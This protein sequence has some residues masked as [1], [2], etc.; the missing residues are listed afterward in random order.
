M[1]SAD[2]H[3]SRAFQMLGQAGLDTHLENPWAGNLS[4]CRGITTK[5]M[6]CG[7]PIDQMKAQAEP[8]LQRLATS[9][10]T[11]DF[12]RLIEGLIG[13]IHCHRHGYR[14]KEQFEGWWV[15][16]EAK[17]KA[18]ARHSDS[19]RSGGPQEQCR[20]RKLALRGE[21]RA[22]E[23]DDI[24]QDGRDYSRPTSRLPHTAK[25]PSRSL[26]KAEATSWSRNGR[27]DENDHAETSAY[28]AHLPADPSPASNSVASANF[29]SEATPSGNSPATPLTIPD[30]DSPTSPIPSWESRVTVPE[31]PTKPGRTNMQP[32][33]GTTKKPF[34]L[35]EPGQD[36]ENADYTTVQTTASKTSG[37]GKCTRSRRPQTPDYIDPNLGGVKYT[38][39]S[40]TKW[41][42]L[43]KIEKQFTDTEN[44]FGS[45]YILQHD[46]DPSCCKVGFTE[47]PVEKRAKQQKCYTSPPVWW[48]GQFRGAN[49]V[50]ALVKEDLAR[51][52]LR[53]VKCKSCEKGH[54]EWFR[55]DRDTLEKKIRAWRSLVQ[56]PLYDDE[57]QVCE[58]E[59]YAL[60]HAVDVSP[61]RLAKVVWSQSKE[62]RRD[63]PAAGRVDG[64]KSLP[65]RVQ[66]GAKFALQKLKPLP[67]EKPPN[68]KLDHGGNTALVR[69]HTMKEMIQRRM[70][71][72]SS[73][74]G[75]SDDAG[76]RREKVLDGWRRM[77]E[78]FR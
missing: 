4:K 54:T 72:F 60:G 43:K 57:G 65:L 28:D 6:P 69:R 63:H 26:R 51:Q 48:T 9:S 25:T 52:Q 66:G 13:S 34:K 16:N 27:E 67:R 5:G 40:V 58:A 55:I 21:S 37:G 47:G 50:E 62:T 61:S 8:K 46:A 3:S 2:T 12:P 17:V 31:T 22:R 33:L 20:G 44:K 73:F 32:R 15:T 23:D 53:V 78:T 39:V 70:S 30:S 36:K 76:S 11:D 10:V 74:T 1:G 24:F 18:R 19:P 56:S 49:R 68:P 75:D 77:K 42:L 38:E 29:W 7:N 41:K 59:G 14:A 71:S 64:E 45:V 35:E